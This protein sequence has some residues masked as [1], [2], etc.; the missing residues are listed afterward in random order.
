M[1]H[2]IMHRV[3]RFM[4]GDCVPLGSNICENVLTKFSLPHNVPFSQNPSHVHVKLMP[5]RV[6]LPFV[7][8]FTFIFICEGTLARTLAGQ[9]QNVSAKHNHNLISL[10]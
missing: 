8:V 5:S 1:S 10:E 9:G 4:L 2:S 6:Q 7:L 3:S